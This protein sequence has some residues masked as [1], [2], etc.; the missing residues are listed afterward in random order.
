MLFCLTASAQ[1][2]PQLNQ[3]QTGTLKAGMLVL[4]GWAIL[5]ILF[6]SFKLT[7][8]SRSRRYFHQMN[9]YWNIVN[10]LIASYALY[11]ILSRPSAG[12]P[13]PDSLQLH[14]LYKS[15]LYLNVGLDVA[16]L[17]LGLYL[18]ERARWATGNEQLQGW[19]QSVLLQGAFLFVLD[20][21]LVVLLEGYTE[22][23]F[24]LVQQ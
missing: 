4:G 9:V 16:Y 13:L 20:L 7:R 18:K 12:L 3:S 21:V 5:N 24:R 6:S 15:L 19:S 10:L 8:T 17:L 2:L 14:T 11:A 23:F 22:P 1:S